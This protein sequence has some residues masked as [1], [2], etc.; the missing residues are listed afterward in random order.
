LN[1]IKEREQLGN[2]T[3]VAPLVF[4]NVST[5]ANNTALSAVPVT[6]QPP[7]LALNIVTKLESLESQKL[8]GPVHFDG[9]KECNQV[10][11]VVIRYSDQDV[12]C[13]LRTPP[14]DKFKNQSRIFLTEIQTSGASEVVPNGSLAHMKILVDLMDQE[15][16]TMN[17]VLSP[18]FL[19]PVKTP[20]HEFFELQDRVKA[21][22]ARIQERQTDDFSMG[23]HLKS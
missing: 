4:R 21:H 19:N 20:M 12:N 6:I 22:N 16:S 7:T 23:S 9:N 1:K 5:A 3:P 10:P 15:F 14:G 13:S 2:Q 18:K 11:D 17:I 8:S